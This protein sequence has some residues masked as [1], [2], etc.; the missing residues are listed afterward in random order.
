MTFSEVKLDVLANTIKEMMQKI[1]RKDELAV[2]RSHVSLFPE[3]KNLTI[4]K[5]FAAHPWHPKTERIIS[6]TR[7]IIWSKMKLK[8]IM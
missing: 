3:K 4:L 2:Q 1:S 6:Y 5:Q 7:F 8:I